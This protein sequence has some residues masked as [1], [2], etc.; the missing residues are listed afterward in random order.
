MNKKI[1]VGLISTAVLAA[2]GSA[3]ASAKTGINF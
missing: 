2:S 1:V 3:L